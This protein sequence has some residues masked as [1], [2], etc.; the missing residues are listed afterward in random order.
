M[1]E[2]QSQRVFLKIITMT[3]F[4]ITMHLN[5]HLNSATK[6]VRKQTNF[7]FL[8]PLQ[9]VNTV[10]ALLLKLQPTS[11]Q[12]HDMLQK[13]TVTNLRKMFFPTD[14]PAVW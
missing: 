8:P 9:T 5:N 13:K 6:I 11:R 1:T 4:C 14:T 10:A 7:M 12:S 2:L 3:P